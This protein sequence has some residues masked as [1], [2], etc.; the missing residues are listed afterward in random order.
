MGKR[1]TTPKKQPTVKE[2]STARRTQALANC[3]FGKHNLSNTFRPGEQVCLTCG[4]VFY[5]AA[6][7]HAAH[8]SPLTKNAYPLDCSTHRHVEMQA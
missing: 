1:W 7:L 4:I 6:C 5:C 3:Q 2:L 8:L